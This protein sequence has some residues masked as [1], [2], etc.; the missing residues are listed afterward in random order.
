VAQAYKILLWDRGC[1]P[2]A[3]GLAAAAEVTW[4]TFCIGVPVATCLFSSNFDSNNVRCL[5]SHIQYRLSLRHHLTAARHWSIVDAANS[6]AT[7]RA[8][9]LGSPV[10]G[11]MVDFAFCIWNRPE[12]IRNWIAIIHS[13]PVMGKGPTMP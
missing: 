2:T 12:P 7:A 3:K 11:R 1:R 4:S 6:G 5:G 8:P 10:V 13:R 9:S